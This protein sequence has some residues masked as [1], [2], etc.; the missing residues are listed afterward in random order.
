MSDL[1]KAVDDSECVL[2]PDVFAVGTGHAEMDNTAMLWG[3]PFPFSS[4]QL[5]LITNGIIWLD[6]N[7][8]KL[9]N[10]DFV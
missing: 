7:S 8:A 6:L 2:V 3:K 9:N 10:E 5:K 1:W 4:W